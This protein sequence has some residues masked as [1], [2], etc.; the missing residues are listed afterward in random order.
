MNNPFEAP[1]QGDGKDARQ[2]S[3]IV[4]PYSPLRDA[5]LIAEKL[6]QSWGGSATQDQIAGSLGTTPRSGTFRNKLGAARV[7][8]AVSVSRGNVKLTDLGHRLVDGQEKAAARVD[9]FFAVPLYEEIYKAY[10][11]KALPPDKGLER[12][13]AELGV[14]AKQTAK[15]RQA[16]KS[17]AQLAGF[18]ETDRGRLIRPSAT[19]NPGKSKEGNEKEKTTPSQVN[20]SSGVPLGDLWMTLLNEGGD[21]SAEKTQEFVDAA[22]TLREVMA[23]DS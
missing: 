7:F 21:W 5:E 13:I 1:G 4:F 9:A 16:F 23:R 17:S 3:S 12:K 6:M 2:R 14:S 18:F 19:S 20:G 10:E 22:R 15:A 11:G 8:G